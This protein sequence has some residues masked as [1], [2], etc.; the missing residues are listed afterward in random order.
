LLAD[1]CKSSRRVDLFKLN[2]KEKEWVKLTSLGDNR[3]LF[4]GFSWSFSAS[5][6]D[7][8]VVKGNC[9][10]SV[11]SEP[12]AVYVFDLDEGQLLP[13]SDYPEYSSLFCEPPEWIFKS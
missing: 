13:I 5:T 12:D 8:R 4:L 7:L 9:V 1:V 2:E 6:L 11:D 10:I 3:V